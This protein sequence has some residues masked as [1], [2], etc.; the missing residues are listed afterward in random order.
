MLCKPY[1]SKE[2]FQEYKKGNLDVELVRLPFEPSFIT[3]ILVPEGEVDVVKRLI[4][5]I[6]G[7]KEF[8]LSLVKSM[9]YTSPLLV[10]L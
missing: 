9:P 5:S 3:D 10:Q 8:D 1:M 7:M 6:P 2:E 4:L